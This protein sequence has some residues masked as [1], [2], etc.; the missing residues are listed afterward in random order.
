MNNN[1]CVTAIMKQDA[2]DLIQAD[3]SRTNC[4]KVRTIKMNK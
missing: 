4:D 2:Y 1:E 3:T